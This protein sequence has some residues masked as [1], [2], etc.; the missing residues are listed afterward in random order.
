MLG[1]VGLGIEIHFKGPF[2]LSSESLES[3]VCR[4][5]SS[6]FGVKASVVASWDELLR[7]QNQTRNWTAAHVGGPFLGPQYSMA[8]V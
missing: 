2:K 1:F 5:R 7:P 6:R 4:P 3:R 8:P